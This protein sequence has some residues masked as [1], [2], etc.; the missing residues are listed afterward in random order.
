MWTKALTCARRTKFSTGSIKM[1]WF[2]AEMERSVTSCIVRFAVS[3]LGGLVLFPPLAA[4]DDK[5]PIAPVR[6]VDTT[7]FGQTIADPYRYMENLKD[8]EVA[9]WMRAQADYTRRLLHR[10]PGRTAIVQEI[11]KYGDAAEARVYNARIV[12]NHI[13]YEKLLANENLPKLYVREGFAGEERLLVDPEAT[14]TPGVGHYALDYY[15]P[16]PDNSY[17]AYGLSP[18]GSEDSV[19]H[20]VSVATGK[21]TS[22]VIDRAQGADPTWLP[23][24]R[25]LYQRLQE[26]G[27]KAPVTD[28]YLN[29]RTFIH[30]LGTTPDKDVALFG[31]GVSKAVKIAPEESGYALYS[32]GSPYVLGIALNGVAREYRIWAAPIAALN[33][34]ATP[35]VQIADTADAVIDASV[36]GDDIYLT[37]HKDAPRYKVVRASMKKPD[38]ATAEVVVPQTEAVITGTV[39]ADDGLY[40]RKMNGGASELFRVPFTPAAEPV[41]VALPFIGDLDNLTADPRQPGVVFFLGGWT[42]FGQYYTA[43]PGGVHDT[44]LAPQGPYDRPPQLVAT[45]VKV[46]ATDGTLVPL[47]LVH[48]DDIELD[49]T[50]PTIVYGYGAYGISQTPFFRPTWLPWFD[51]GGVLAVA[52]V[53]GGGEYGEEWHKAGFQETKPNTWKDAILCGQWLIA[54]H[55]TSTQRI[56][57]MGGSAGG[58]MVGRAITERPDLFGAAVDQVPVSD[59]L[60]FETSA[61]G[62][63]NIPEFGT[64]TTEAGFKSLLAMSPYQAVKDSTKY[65]AVLLVTGIN[66]PRVDAWE[67]AK[68]TARLQAASVSGKPILLRIDY[69]AGHGYGSTKKQSYDQRADEFTF[70]L[71]QAGIE[72]FQP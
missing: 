26:L 58:I 45:E 28:K 23:D 62:T 61:N 49:G 69:D 55:Y 6:N 46:K 38:L 56:S 20:I 60:R 19:I 36:H 5:P 47:S 48:R 44:Q 59:A 71:W 53:R 7:Y 2:Y 12:G 3:V 39:A 31:A 35:W 27:P 22:D 30:V 65:P 51:R 16:A 32:S 40:V 10:I 57:I 14:T 24:G 8:P 70:L 68:L 13:Y 37:T 63:P 15:A 50:H 52:H 18:G 42:R 34:A 64:V 1:E 17:V 66:D 21:P 25:L 43:D 11:Q 54:N 4:A 9:S 67:A 29:Q 33:G 41:K 72:E